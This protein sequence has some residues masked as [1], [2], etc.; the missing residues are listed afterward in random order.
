MEPYITLLIHLVKM[1][2]SSGIVAWIV[3]CIFRKWLLL[4]LVYFIARGLEKHNGKIV[5]IC[6]LLSS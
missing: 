5:R 2:W 1:C 6:I 4:L 3:N